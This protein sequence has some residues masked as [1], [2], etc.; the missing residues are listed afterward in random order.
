MYTDHAALRY[1]FV[2]VLGSLLEGL[3]PAERARL[4][5]VLFLAHTDPSVHPFH[6]APWTR[7]LP[8]TLLDYKTHADN[9]EAYK[10]GVNSSCVVI[11]YLC[12]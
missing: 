10:D 8:D 9:E 3:T 11:P 1:L 6:D 2:A 12:N 7:Q 5:I 4:H